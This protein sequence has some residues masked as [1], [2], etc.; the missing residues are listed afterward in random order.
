MINLPLTCVFPSDDMMIGDPD[1]HISSK[2][3]GKVESYIITE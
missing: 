3:C 1:I 2:T